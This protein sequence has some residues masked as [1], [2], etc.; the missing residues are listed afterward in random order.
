MERLF[1]T[2]NKEGIMRNHL[3]T[4]W[5]HIRRSPY[6]AAA[7]VFSMTLMFFV[8]AV[9]LLAAFGVQ[10]ILH[11]FEQQPQITAF[12]SDIVTEEEI[13]QLD[14]KLKGTRKYH[15]NHQRQDKYNRHRG[16]GKPC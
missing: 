3:R 15:P 7:A 9:F 2:K 5:H 12:F 13:R 14:E 16:Y 6:Q 10:M 8:A 1:A 11:S 4:T